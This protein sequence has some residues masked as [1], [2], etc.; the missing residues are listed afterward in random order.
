MAQRSSGTRQS[1][2]TDRQTGMRA[3][4][5]NKP[6]KN[7]N[8]EEDNPIPTQKKPS[9]PQDPTE[10]LQKSSSNSSLDLES[11]PATDRGAAVK[12]LRLEVPTRSTDAQTQVARTEE[13]GD[14][15]MIIMVLVQIPSR[16]YMHASPCFVFVCVR[17]M[18]RT[19]L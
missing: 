11:T 16:T 6:D 12:Q 15:K 4:Q 7:K 8:N 10:E 18:R 9:T 5:Q 14:S 1:K 13:Q 3:E 19:S 17:E 2:Q